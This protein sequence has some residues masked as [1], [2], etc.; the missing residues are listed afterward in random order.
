MEV[1]GS[2]SDSGFSPPLPLD[3]STWTQADQAS[4]SQAAGTAVTVAVAP[5]L[6][7]SCRKG[8]DYLACFV[9]AADETHDFINELNPFQCGEAAM[10]SMAAELTGFQQ[11]SPPQTPVR[12]SFPPQKSEKK[13]ILQL[14]FS[15]GTMKTPVE[16]QNCL[17]CYRRMSSS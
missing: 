4:A 9:A 8:D 16:D 12:L 3:M 14:L 6:P 13:A 7:P 17:Y 15:L 2:Q 11:P 5:G 1:P 10:G